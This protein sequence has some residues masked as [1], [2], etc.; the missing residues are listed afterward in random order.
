MYSTIPVTKPY[1]PSNEKYIGLVQQVYDTAILTNR[2]PMVRN[3]E[4]RLQNY[5][6]VKH[7]ICVANGTIAL[8]V[9]Y[10][11]LGLRG[12]V[13][14]TP[15]TFAA[16]SS[17]IEWSGL[18][19]VYS[20]IDTRSY[21][22]DIR[23]VETLIDENTAAIAP[24][25]VFGNPCEVELLQKIALERDIR[26]IYD[27]SH[28]FGVKYVEG[29]K[30]KSVLTYGDVSTLSFHA[31]KLFH[32][33]EGGAICT[34]DDALAEVI[35][36]AINFGITG[37]SNII[38][39]GINGKMN[40]FEAAMGLC[41]LDDIDF[42]INRREEIWSAYVQEL[43]GVVEFQSWNDRSS[44]NYAYA[45]ILFPSEEKLLNAIDNL[46]SYNVLARRY[47]HPSL[48][49]L[50]CFNNEQF[51]MISRDISSRIL[52]LPIYTDLEIS[53]VRLI[54]EQVKKACKN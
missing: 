7:V 51:C 2:G 44:N 26:L 27:A 40:E 15:F 1:L 8:Q 10:K 52:C 16:T 21:N 47:F 5:L 22:M 54:C 14:T 3:L 34:E 41:V 42:I 39:S 43:H 18:P 11:V 33:I 50:Q 4:E 17:A 13:I 37:P 48:D 49:T 23:S 30:S 53:S 32:T 36:N 9:A 6:G 20:D 19:I 35:R 38:Q 46:Q 25:H 45:P 29:A 24:V 28:C 12:N 31:T